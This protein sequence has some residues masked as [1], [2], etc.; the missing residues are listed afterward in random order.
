MHQK[1][2][3]KSLYFCPSSLSFTISEAEIPHSSPTNSV[4]VECFTNSN[5][6]SCTENPGA[7]GK[8]EA[9]VP[10][11]SPMVCIW[12]STA[13]KPPPIHS[14]REYISRREGSSIYGQAKSNT[15]LYGHLIS[16]H[17]QMTIIMQICKS[18]IWIPQPSS[19]L[20]FGVCL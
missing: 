16:D 11:S 4:T 15:N 3:L 6:R 13:T 2:L 19:I 14:V 12:F 10:C 1:E 8:N 9:P 7:P 20:I 18:H 5:E 17:L